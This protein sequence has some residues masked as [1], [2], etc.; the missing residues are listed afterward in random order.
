MDAPGPPNLVSK[1]NRP[2]EPASRMVSDPKDIGP[3]LLLAILKISPSASKNRTSTRSPQADAGCAENNTPAATTKQLKKRRII[4]AS[5]EQPSRK[6][7][8]GD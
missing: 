5:G 8:T 4:E 3:R 7:E 2:R 1:I 6:S